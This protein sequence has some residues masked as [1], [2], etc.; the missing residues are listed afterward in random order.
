MREQFIEHFAGEALQGKRF[1]LVDFLNWHITHCVQISHP[2]LERNED[3]QAEYQI[4]VAQGYLPE[5]L[6]FVDESACNWNTT[7]REY[8]WAPINGR[9]CRWDYFVQGKW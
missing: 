1:V 6:V 5:Q 7:K 9:A 4:K 8:G 2:A 3:H